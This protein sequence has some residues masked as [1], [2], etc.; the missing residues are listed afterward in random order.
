MPLPNP[1]NLTQTAHD[2]HP[3]A[4]L[5]GAIQRLTQPP[6]P[7]YLELGLAVLP[8]GL[9]T[10]ALPG[11]GRVLLDLTAGA[12]RYTPPD[13][14]MTT[15]PIQS[16]TQAAL[17]ADLFGALAA[18]EL[19]GVLPPGA[20]LFERVS[21][22]IAARGGRYRPPQRAALL[23]ETPSQVDPRAAGDFGAALQ[24]VFSGMAR[25]LARRM[26]RTTPLV[27]WPEGFDLSTLIL[28]GTE[29]DESQP[30]LNFGFAPFSAGVETP[31]LYAYAY[32]TPPGYTPPQLPA[33]A[34]WNT[35]SWTG[36]MLDYELIAGQPDP[37]GFVDAS[38]TAIYALLRPLLEG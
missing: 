10:G 32:P 36:V 33:G 14:K 21:Q 23:D 27:V 22:G 12:L 34:R 28:P 4:E 11:G 6:R 8:E 24:T 35:Q 7:A 31:Y 26:E 9:S 13:R 30:H 2:L 25:F 37:I 16:R 29:I 38:C 18:D 17:F 20:G 5:L 3:C 15:L 1:K 19:A